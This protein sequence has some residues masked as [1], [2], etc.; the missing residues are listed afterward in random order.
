MAIYL[1]KYEIRS[2]PHTRP[3]D[4]IPIK[5]SKPKLEL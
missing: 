1:N 4:K 2:S 5:I 3:K